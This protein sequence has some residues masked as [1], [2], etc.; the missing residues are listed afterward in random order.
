MGRQNNYK[1]RIVSAKLLLAAG[2]ALGIMLGLA[3][4]FGY[5]LYFPNVNDDGGYFFVRTGYDKDDVVEALAQSGLIRSMWTLE[6]AMKYV[7]YEKIYAGRFHI[8]HG[9][10]SK[11]ILRMLA[12]NMQSPVN[13]HIPSVQTKEKMA[14]IIASQ[15]EL[16]SA[17]IADAIGDDAS[18]RRYGFNKNNFAWMFLPNTYQVYWN[19]S[20]TTFLNRIHREWRI[21]W[22]NDDRER[23]LKA[24]K[25]SRMQV[26][27][28]ASI[29]SSETN[30]IDE[31]PNIAGVYINRLNAGMR[32][33]ADPTVRYAQSSMVRH[34]I[35]AK[36]TRK[37]HAYNTYII[38]GLPPGPINIPAP[39]H[40]DA[41]L[42][43]KKHK[44]LYFCAREDFSGYH[45]FSATYTQHLVNARK[46]QRELNKKEIYR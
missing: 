1:R 5:V 4:F 17:A 24:L 3:L 33:Q 41:V 16:D 26:I 6:C 18:A 35:L 31:M 30:K 23:K 46:Y 42:N 39:E 21:F 25:M 15:I 10:S 38:Y 43:Y 29:V 22:E 7:N 11:E 14:A 32:L 37:P 20:L 9:M 27:T 40:I 19:V 45:N 12:G 28:L 13:L 36:D 2:T 8:T 34:R 44:Y